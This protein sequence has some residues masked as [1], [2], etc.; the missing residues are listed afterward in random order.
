MNCVLKNPNI[1]PRNMANISWGRKDKLMENANT[2][3]LFQSHFW[4]PLQCLTLWICL[5]VMKTS[6]VWGDYHL[7]CNQISL[8]H[9]IAIL[10]SS[11][12]LWEMA[13]RA[14]RAGW[15]ANLLPCGQLVW[16]PPWREQV[17][18]PNRLP[19]PHSDGP[20]T[21]TAVPRKT[22][23]NKTQKLQYHSGS[24]M[25]PPLLPL[26]CFKFPNKETVGNQK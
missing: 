9:L 17:L 12:F 22:K 19:E 7:N 20:W 6:K 10:S 16:S 2:L 24:Q 11:L 25:Q 26:T 5:T 3:L 13:V 18:S 15:W 14:Y 4:L 1:T 21:G 23:Q 8:F